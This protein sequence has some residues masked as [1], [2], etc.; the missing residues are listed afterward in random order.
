MHCEY[1]TNVSPVTNPSQC[2]N[3]PWDKVF[4]IPS[5]HPHLKTGNSE[6][7]ESRQESEPAGEDR[8][9]VSQPAKTA[10]SSQQEKN[11]SSEKLKTDNT[12]S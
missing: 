9:R 5:A 7:R 2:R 3:E 4:T 6:S 1:T 8:E 10:V 11:E 12:E